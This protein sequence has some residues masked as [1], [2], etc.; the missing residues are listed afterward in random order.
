VRFEDLREEV[1]RLL[2]GGPEHPLPDDVFNDLA[3]SVFRFQCRENGPYGGFVTRRGINPDTLSRWESIPF[4]PTR[5]FK[6]TALVAGDP[7]NVERVFR[8]SGTT[9]GRDRRGEHHVLD[10]S[11]YRGSLLG[12]FRTHIFPEGWKSVRILC[13]LPSPDSVPDSSLSYMMG[14]VLDAMGGEGSGFYVREDGELDAEDLRD[15]LAGSEKEG[16]EGMELQSAAGLKNHGNWRV[17]GEE[18]GCPPDRP[19]RIHGAGPGRPGGSDRER[20]R[21]DGAS[22]SILRADPDRS[23]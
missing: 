9:Q 10:L 15:A 11:L 17:Q 19:L 4:L 13:L 8:T 14:E 1:L 18:S 16:H 22:F 2:H 23:P 5:A 12:T 6:S 3:L 21:D 7:A 20:V